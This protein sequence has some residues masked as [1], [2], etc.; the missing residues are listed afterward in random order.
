VLYLTHNPA[1]VPGS[2]NPFNLPPHPFTDSQLVEIFQYYKTR[3]TSYKEMYV[4]FPIAPAEVNAVL[5]KGKK[6]FEQLE[7]KEL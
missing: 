3:C 2:H 1:P 4:A 7:T 5:L 6:L